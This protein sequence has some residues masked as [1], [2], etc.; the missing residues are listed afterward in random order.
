M[1]GGQGDGCSAAHSLSG[2]Q[3]EGASAMFNL[4]PPLEADTQ[5]ADR[6]E[7]KWRTGPACGALHFCLTF[8]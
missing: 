1:G 6:K 7:R 8:V 5:L 3:G 2:T 4:G